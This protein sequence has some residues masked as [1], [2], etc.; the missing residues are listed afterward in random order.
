MGDVKIML[1]VL[2]IE[3]LYKQYEEANVLVNINLE[4][5]QNDFICILGPSG[6]GKSTLLRCIM[7]FEQYNGRILIDGHPMRSDVVEC[8]TVFQDVN[9]LFPW[10]T[11]LKN[12]MYPLLVKGEHKLDAR[13]KARSYLDKVNMLDYETYYPYQLSG[14]MK[15][16]VAIARTLAVKPK[17]ILM[18][19]PFASLDAMTRNQL[20]DELLRIVQNENVTVLF[21][22]HNIQEAIVLSNRIVMLSSEGEKKLDIRNN[23]EKPVSPASAG[24]GN[25]WKELNDKLHSK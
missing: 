2:S 17:L 4:V 11:V 23:L 20:E 14:G 22:T 9:Q 25:L 6:C 3:S 15:Q 19:E 16:R 10:K 12:V 1:P 7:G 24:Y 18:D 5:N 8:A 21:I 13:K